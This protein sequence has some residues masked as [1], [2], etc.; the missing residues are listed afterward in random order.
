MSSNPTINAYSRPWHVTESKVPGYERVISIV[1]SDNLAVCRLDGG[2]VSN[3]QALAQ[4]RANAS[5]IVAAVNA[6]VGE[7]AEPAWEW[8]VQS[9]TG[10]E[11]HL[12]K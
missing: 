9:T 1:T 5:L 3:P 7:E 6:V 12:T 10:V 4:V 11:F 2:G 8:G